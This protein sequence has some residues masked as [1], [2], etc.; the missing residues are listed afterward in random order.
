[1]DSKQFSRIRHYLGKTQKQLA[2]LLCVSLKTVQ[3]YE[4]DWRKIPPSSERQVLLLL[5]CEASQGKIFKPCWEISDCPSGWRD[6]C[7][8]YQYKEGHLCWSVNGT[9]CQGKHQENWD[10]KI[11]LCRKCKVFKARIPDADRLLC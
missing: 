10:I 7:S 4:Q 9:F 11:N 6:M 2:H 8:A 5:F 3:S 1:M